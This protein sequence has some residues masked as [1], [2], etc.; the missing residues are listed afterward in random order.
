MPLVIKLETTTGLLVPMGTALPIARGPQDVT[1]QFLNSGVAALLAEGA[2]I[3][4]KLYALT[5]T[6]NPIATFSDWTAVSAFSCYAANINP[7]AVAAMGYLQAGTL[8]GRLS[9]GDPATDTPLF[10]VLWG[11][12]GEVTG[13]PA[14]P[15]I[16]T[17]PAGPV[18]YMQDLGYFQGKVTADQVE[19][20]W[21]APQAALISGLSLHTQNAPAGADLI[22]E[23]IVNGAPT[24]KTATLTAGNKS[25]YADFAGGSL[26]VA[27]G[28]TLQFKPTQAGNARY[29]AVKAKAQLV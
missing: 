1:L 21:K 23:L 18:T 10:H 29:L 8:L 2:P 22:V 24:G 20:Y 6:L 26:A 3:A 11:G 12:S 7:L 13:A 5:D 25:I 17:Q 28:D 14:Q 27:A 9:Y 19:G 4:L 16:I 15:I